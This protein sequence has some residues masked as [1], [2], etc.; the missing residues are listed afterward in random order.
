M[1]KAQPDCCENFSAVKKI[2]STCGDSCVLLFCYVQASLVQTGPVLL[3]VTVFFSFCVTSVE[4]EKDQAERRGSFF[5]KGVH[6]QIMAS[7]QGLTEYTRERTQQNFALQW[8][9]F[10]LL[11]SFLFPS[12]SFFWGIALSLF[13][14]VSFKS[15][16]VHACMRL[17]QCLSTRTLNNT[18]PESF[19]DGGHD[20]HEK[21]PRLGPLPVFLPLSHHSFIP[22]PSHLLLL[23][24]FVLLC[25]I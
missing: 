20:L 2:S 24:C 13:L 11:Y 6:F 1:F 4:P 19:R 25:I 23:P 3:H 16:S 14:S 12:P 21:W 18:T 5:G 22:N 7:L 8:L 9:S 15:P 17:H 10:Y